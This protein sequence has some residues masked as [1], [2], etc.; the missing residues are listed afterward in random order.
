VDRCPYPATLGRVEISTLSDRGAELV[1]KLVDI[2]LSIRRRQA[3][4]RR[5]SFIQ[6]SGP[7]VRD[8]SISVP[9]LEGAIA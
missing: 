2:P 8:S 5:R 9:T 7:I 3:Y 4:D 1:E 6:P